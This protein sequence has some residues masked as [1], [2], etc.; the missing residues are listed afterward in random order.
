MVEVEVAIATLAGPWGPYHVA[1][2]ARGVVAAEW[3][4][5]RAAF[6]AALARRL[7]ATLVQGD[8]ARAVLD[9]ARPRIEAV[10]A[11]DPVD[12]TGLPLDLRDRPAF[13]RDVLLTV[14][15]VPWGRTASYGEIA[16][17]VGSPRAARAVGGAVKRNP[18]SMLIPCHRIVAA[19]GTLGGYGG[20]DPTERADALE[21]K[22]TLLLREGIT[23]SARDG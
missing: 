20:D 8:D 18:I 19:D 9:A 2:T 11:G 22:R 4:V 12:T 6:E 15:D 7:A 17:R 23:M 13:D 21:R 16:R 3:A 5:G 10:L 14:R 1:A